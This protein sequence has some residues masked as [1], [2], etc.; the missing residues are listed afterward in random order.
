MEDIE[1]YRNIGT[2]VKTARCQRKWKREE[3]VEALLEE[4][5]LRGIE[6]RNEWEFWSVRIL[7][8]RLHIPTSSIIFYLSAGDNALINL[9]MD[10]L[11]DLRF[12]RY[13]KARKE[14]EQF[15]R[16]CDKKNHFQM[17]AYYRLYMTWKVWQRQREK[18]E[19]EIFQEFMESEMPGFEERLLKGR[20]FAPDELALIAVYYQFIEED[21]AKRL[22]KLY[23]VVYYYREEF[24][25]EQEKLQPFYAEL[26]FA[27]AQCQYE[28]EDYV[29]CIEQCEEGIKVTKKTRICVMAGELYEWMADAKGKILEEE[30]DKE[31]QRYL[32]EEVRERKGP[33]LKEKR[34]EISLFKGMG[35]RKQIDE[36]LEDYGCADVLYDMYYSKYEDK[37]KEQLE[38]KMERWKTMM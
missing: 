31:R 23:Y 35:R 2:Q 38:R 21:T 36:I 14:I 10:I 20:A 27:C 33:V 8:G 26:M 34:E 1:N 18:K 12:W 4:P 37:Y 22:Q 9:E 19:K 24:T 25:R 3:V 29:N 13:E 16:S 15:Y 32:R 7:M 5:D 30:M 17:R 11:C 28:L 6:E